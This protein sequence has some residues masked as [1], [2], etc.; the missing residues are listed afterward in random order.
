MTKD[1]LVKMIVVEI[2]CACI[3]YNYL[4]ECKVIFLI[5][6]FYFVMYLIEKTSNAKIINNV[7]RI[8]NRLINYFIPLYYFITP[9]KKSGVNTVAHSCN[10]SR[11]IVSLT[12]FPPRMSKLWIVL[13]TLL[14]QTHKPDKILLWLASSQIPSLNFVDKKVLKLC[15]RGVEIRFCEDLKSHKKYFY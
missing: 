8:L 15:K 3:S 10:N 12:S 9:F 5:N 14:R 4:L 13:E 11:V 1:P 2:R 7:Y 6:F